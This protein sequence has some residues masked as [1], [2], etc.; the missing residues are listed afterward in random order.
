MGYYSDATSSHGTLNFQLLPQTLV[1]GYVHGIVSGQ[2]KVL[3]T[4]FLFFF[5]ANLFK[6]CWIACIQ[7]EVEVKAATF[8]KLHQ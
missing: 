7:L 6:P 3:G 5:A 8:E 4:N 2:C 1:M